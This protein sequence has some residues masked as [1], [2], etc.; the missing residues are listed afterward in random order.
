[1]I[2]SELKFWNDVYAQ[3]TGVSHAESEPVSVSVSSPPLTMPMTVPPAPSAIPVTEAQ[4]PMTS[5]PF[6]S[7]GDSF[8]PNLIPP[9]WDNPVLH[10][11]L[12]C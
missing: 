10:R 1:M 5:N 11:I 2:K 9:G 12:L 8:A 3:D 6:V 7:F 4:A